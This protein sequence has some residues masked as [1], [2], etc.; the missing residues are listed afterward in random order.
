MK[1]WNDILEKLKRKWQWILLAA[2]AL[3][4]ASFWILGFKTEIQ[5]AL[6]GYSSRTLKVYCGLTIL[7]L[8]L[9]LGLG[10]LFIK[11]KQIRLEKLLLICVLISGL[12]WMGIMPPLTAPDEINHYA[13]A[14]YR[15]N[16]LLFQDALDENGMVRMRAEDANA[17]FAVLKSQTKETY[18]AFYEG[19]FRLCEEP[20]MVSFSYEP[21]RTGPLPHMPQAIGITLGRLLHLGWA[22]TMLLGRLGNFLFFVVCIYQA[23]KRIPF[24]K[25]IFFMASMLPMTLELV[26][27]VS[28]DVVPLS[29][30]FLFTAICFQDIFVKERMEKR[31]VAVLAVLL[32]VL[33][34]CKIV[35][36]L[37]AGLC[38]L[39]PKEKFG[40]RR[41]YFCSAAA[42]LFLAA[43][44]LTVNNMATLAEYT[45]SGENY[46]AWADAPGYT[47]KMLL[48]N[49]V[50]FLFLMLNTIRIQAGYY[51]VTMVGGK[52]GALNIPLS[53]FSVL[54]FS[55]LLLLAAL[56]EERETVFLTIR[57]KSWCLAV[58][59]GVSF[60][61]LLSMLL[62]WT[63]VGEVYICG[64]QG[65]YFLPV[66]PLFLICL[67]NRRFAIS[68]SAAKEGALD[69]G[70]IIAAVVFN[71]LA[72]QH[73]AALMLVGAG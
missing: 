9:A 43:F 1:G 57:Q 50:R 60:L 58:C 70:M 36:F 12:A 41:F 23:V 26:S 66:L 13:T 55:A 59:A 62:G 52:L 31:D 20:E 8:L 28:Y 5:A 22:G 27:S 32:M 6:A 53:E 65:R 35:Y 56:K 69:Q 51:W 47:L 67:Q 2:V 7:M 10:I 19:L 61:V 64:V 68:G 40:S 48:F 46:I 14:Y 4:L 21:V 30:A 15:S 34:P 63:P 16:Q 11:K 73:A 25:M 45:G 3:F 17:P 38:L 72:L 39:I 33:V 37:L 29:M 42:V 18:Q 49:P 24:G 44:S 71:A 54:G